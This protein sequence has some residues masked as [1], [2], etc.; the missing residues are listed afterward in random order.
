MN[1]KS[2]SILAKFV[3]SKPE[4]IAIV[5]K[6]LL[7]LTTHQRQSKRK[8]KKES[9]QILNQ[10]ALWSLERRWTASFVRLWNAISFRKY[11][12][13]TTHFGLE[14][15]LRHLGVA[16]RTSVRRYERALIFQDCLRIS[17]HLEQLNPKSFFLV[18]P[19]PATL[20]RREPTPSICSTNR[21]QTFEAPLTSYN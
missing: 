18:L 15:A 16:E 2:H 6:L 3:C 14:V 21:R 10:K 8:T 5:K 4:Q 11:L 13:A 19:K 12:P 1:L 9:V 20:W 17:Q 7:L